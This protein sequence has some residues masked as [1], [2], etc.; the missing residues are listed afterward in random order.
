MLDGPY[1]L[2]TGLL[3]WIRY[4]RMPEALLTCTLWLL[5]LIILV[6]CYICISVV[7]L[8][9]SFFNLPTKL[10]EELMKHPNCP[11]PVHALGLIEVRL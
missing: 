10:S 9:S 5:N 11:F 2:E 7:I 3:F 1:C 8:E 4:C 6:E